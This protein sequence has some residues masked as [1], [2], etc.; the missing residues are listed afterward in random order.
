MDT[1]SNPPAPIDATKIGPAHSLV[2]WSAVRARSRLWQSAVAL[3]L[4]SGKTEHVVIQVNQDTVF[5]SYLSTNTRNLLKRTGILT[6]QELRTQTPEQ[7]LSIEN[8]GTQRLA[9]VTALIEYFDAR[10]PMTEASSKLTNL[11]GQ[12]QLLISDFSQGKLRSLVGTEIDVILDHITWLHT[13]VA[14][15]VGSGSLENRA[16]MGWEP[17]RRLNDSLRPPA[18]TLTD[19]LLRR[20]FSPNRYVAWVVDEIS[21]ALTVSSLDDEISQL[22]AEFNDRAVDILRSRYGLSK[23]ETFA[24]L[25]RRLGVTRERVRQLEIRTAEKLA[26]RFSRRPLPKFR[27]AMLSVEQEQLASADEIRMLLHDRGLAISDSAIT[28]FLSLW[29]MLS[30]VQ[31]NIAKGKARHLESLEPFPG[32]DSKK[33][34]FRRPRAS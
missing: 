6:L 15:Q 24:V 33:W 27:T 26:L 32:R 25:S 7:L 21:K 8:F 18:R 2:D 23:R 17:V 29:R 19:F 30:V 11:Q 4:P 12:F 9:E 10:E 22:V 14:R 31:D 16:L 1:S 3:P 20:Q 28:D 5:F 13:E 34:P